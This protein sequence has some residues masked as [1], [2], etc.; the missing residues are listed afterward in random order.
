MMSYRRRNPEP[1]VAMR[2]APPSRAKMLRWRTKR[3][4]KAMSVVLFYVL[5]VIGLAHGTAHVVVGLALVR[6]RLGL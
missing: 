3:A 6:L 1:E 4:A 2:P 5:G